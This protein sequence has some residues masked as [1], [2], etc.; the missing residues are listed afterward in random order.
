[1]EKLHEEVGH[2]GV[3]ETY[4]RV[5]MRFWW[6]GLKKKVKRQVASCEACQK[7]SSLTPKE[8]GHATH[9]VCMGVSRRRDHTIPFFFRVRSVLL[10]FFNLV[11]YI[12]P[13]FGLSIHPFFLSPCLTT[14]DSSSTVVQRR[15]LCILPSRVEGRMGINSH[16]QLLLYSSVEE[17]SSHPTLHSKGQDASSC[18]P[19]TP[20][21]QQCR[22]GVFASY[23]PQQRVG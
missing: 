5:V 21:L 17:E 13:F 9:W 19:Y 8:I 15:S 16:P 20:P 7:R 6:P 2:K 14:F 22:G 12:V 3:E 1:M 23:P 10:A 4:R 18:S 11:Q